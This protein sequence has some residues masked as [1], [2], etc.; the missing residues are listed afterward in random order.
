MEKEIKK[1]LKRAKKNL[2]SW[3]ERSNCYDPET[4]EWLRGIIEGLQRAIS[5][6]AKEK[7]A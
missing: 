4:E 1:E 2:E 7:N 3:Y 6:F 5:L